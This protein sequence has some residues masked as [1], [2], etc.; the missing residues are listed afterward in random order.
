MEQLSDA[1]AQPGSATPGA[2]LADF[3]VFATAMNQPV[4]EWAAVLQRLLSLE[5]LPSV[6]ERVP[7][8]TLDRHRTLA[9]LAD[10]RVLATAMNQVVPEWA[11]VLELL[12]RH[13]PRGP[14]HLNQCPRPCR[15]PRNPSSR[16]PRRW[17]G[18]ATR[19][20]S[21]HAR[22]GDRAGC[23]SA[24]S[25]ACAR[26]TPEFDPS[27]PRCRGSIRDARC[28]APHRR[29]DPPPPRSDLPTTKRSIWARWFPTPARPL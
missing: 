10:F 22:G 1:A 21:A 14:A 23:P 6:T 12:L 20:D 17:S 29:P 24:A 3:R 9:M 13:P 16:R 2:M 11:G 25:P 8:Q 5:P 15:Q 27:R 18:R 4:P 19:G 28:R 7:L 26:F